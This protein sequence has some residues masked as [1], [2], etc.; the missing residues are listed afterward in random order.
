MGIF[1]ALL[2]WLFISPLLF[3]SGLMDAEVL[4]LDSEWISFL[5]SIYTNNTLEVGEQE[6]GLS[7]DLDLQNPCCPFT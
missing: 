6:V 1:N 2:K 5:I 3:L 4:E 7:L